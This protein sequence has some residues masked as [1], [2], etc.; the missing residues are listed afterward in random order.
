MPMRNAKLRRSRCALKAAIVAVAA[1]IFWFSAQTGDE[2]GRASGAV[3]EFILS[4][5]VP[6]YR[7]LSPT[8]RAQLMERAG[9][10]VRKLAHFTEFALLGGLLAA[11]WALGRT[12]GRALPALTPAWAVATLYAC[13]D[14]LHQMFVAGR[15]PSPMDV[16]ID[17]LGALAGAA[18]AMVMLARRKRRASRPPGARDG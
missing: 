4:I 8:N 11:D 17:S 18:A 3:V 6:G 13:T 2:S 1:M 7:G 12:D 15:G 5:I 16:G 10:I 9:L 14:E